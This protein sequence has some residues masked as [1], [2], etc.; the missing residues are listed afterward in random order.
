MSEIGNV[1]IP[2]SYAGHLPVCPSLESNEQI[3]VTHH[4]FNFRLARNSQ[5]IV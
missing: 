5:T 1:A 3:V 2:E 4:N